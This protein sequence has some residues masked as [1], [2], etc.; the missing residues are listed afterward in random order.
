MALSKTRLTSDIEDNEVNIPG[1]NIFRCDSENRNTGEVIIKIYKYIKDDIKYEV[2]LREKM[3]YNCWCIGIGMRDNGYKGT[4]AVVYHSPSASDGDFIRF[5]NNIMD[6]LVVKGQCI[7]I[8]DFDMD[9]MKDS[10]YKKKVNNRNDIC[11][12]EAIY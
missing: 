9:L 3:K 5:M 7:V 12:Y 11:R 10:F 1:Y 4:I 6:V 2:I 8:R